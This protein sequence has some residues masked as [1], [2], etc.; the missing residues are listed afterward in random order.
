MA[1]A[2]GSLRQVETSIPARMDRLPWTRWHWLVVAALGTVWILDGLEV[3][4]VGAIGSVLAKKETL[5]FSST[6]V[7]LQA[8]VYLI[9][10]VL[11][12]LCFGYLTDRMGRKRLFDITLGAYLVATLATAFSESFWMFAVC[13]FFTGMGIGGEYAAINSAIDELIPARVRGWVD[14][15]INGSYWIGAAVGA[16]GQIFLLNPDLFA[17]DFGWRLGFGIGAVLG[18]IILL[19]RRAVPES[20][21]WLM[22][23][24][25]DQ[26]ADRIVDDIEDKVLRDAGLD[27]VEEP[28]ESITIQQREKTT[29]AEILRTM[30]RLHPKRSVLGLS[31]MVSQAFFY[32]ALFFTYALVLSTFYK[33]PAEN[34][35]YYLLAFAIGNFLGPVAL[36]RL[37]DTVGRRT[38][39]TLTYSLSAVLLAITAWLFAADLLTA[40]TQTIAWTIIF[41]VASASASSAYLTVSEVLPLET[42]AM[43]I[44]V[45]YSL[46]TGLGGIAAP[47]L[48]GA[49][50]GTRERM[51]LFWGFM[52][53]A[54][55]L[56]AAAAVEWRLGVDAEQESLEDVARPLAA[57][58]EG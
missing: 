26:E 54:A 12:S 3:T 44:A 43:A 31:L 13:R 28:E 42:R 47:A 46:G 41:F 8:T 9:G 11:G 14:L 2:D 39:I 23:H 51:P 50:I 22:I 1:A 40:V 57:E 19:L 15:C 58:G 6:Q 18:L 35:P 49:L 4:I 27:A 45:F 29:I 33:V 30:F 16:F 53:G 5:G 52:F 48:F 55:L 32:N 25:R 20:P 36:G 37:F 38:M 24:G 21:R 10:A 17:V 56:A 7:G 34:A